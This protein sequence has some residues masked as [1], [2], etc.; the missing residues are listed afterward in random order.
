MFY[1]VTQL[2]MRIFKNAHWLAWHEDFQ[3]SMTK[4]EML[5]IIEKGNKVGRFVKSISAV[6]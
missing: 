2:S 1:M 4:I 6:N 5:I 3:I